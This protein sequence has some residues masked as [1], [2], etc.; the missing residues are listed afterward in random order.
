VNIINL[1]NITKSYTDRLLF[2]GASFFVAE[3]EKVGV[4]GIN[5]TGKS[6][7][8]RI[9]SG[10]EEPDEGTVIR[11]R[12]LVI[13]TLPQA[14]E[15]DGTKTIRENLSPALSGDAVLEAVS[16]LTR[17]NFKNLDRPVAELSGGQKKKLALAIA[18]SKPADVLILDEP[19]NH[20]DY[21]MIEWLQ[22][23]LT[24]FRGTVIM[25]THDRYFLDEVCDRIVEIDRGSIYSFDTNYSGYLEAKAERLNL[26]RSSE[27]KRQNILRREIAWIRR[28]AR[29]RSTKQKAHIR[30]Y[31]ELRDR[32][33]PQS[34]RE[35]FAL[36][37]GASR[38]GRTT[39]EIEHL[40]YGYAANA[41]IKDFTYVFLKDDRVGFIGNNG[42]GKTTLMRLIAGELTPQAGSVTIGQTIKLGY[43]T[44]DAVLPDPGKRVIDFVKDIGEYI[45]TPEGKI[46]ATMMLERFLFTPDQQF[47][48]IGKL[49]GGEKRRLCLLSV[50]MAAPNVLI[51]DEPTNDLDTETLAVL[52]DYLENF[53]GIVITVSH[54]RH[55]LDRIVN[56]LFCFEGDGVLRRYE[57]NYT[58]YLMKT[59]V[60][61]W[62]TD[63]SAD[64][65]SISANAPKKASGSGEPAATPKGDTRK[66]REKKL[67]F[68][69]QEQKEYDSI[70]GDIE[71]LEAEISGLEEEMSENARDFEKLAGLSSKKEALEELLLEK[72]ERF[73]VLE[74]KAREIAAESP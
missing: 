21:G 46:S 53:R 18:L 17:L 55:F 33:V 4:V 11:A 61:F 60:H 34:A 26:E 25:V 47:S 63:A 9:I 52:E 57:G 13:S 27:Q 51:L 31:E 30:R 1:E 2:R 38:M 23:Y 15:F 40:S 66:P 39:V 37:S 12:H 69:Y 20:L 5:G 6:T 45:P 3:G 49:S 44:Q 58:D 48:P 71:K 70:E 36:A 29:A 72:M 43:Y 28:G 7:L 41:L 65:K 74:N 19:T 50:L 14:P 59:P 64:P 42:C 32:E 68:T 67:R 62:E 35:E 54:D 16:I 24:S 56:R 8:L 10:E 22:R 73:E